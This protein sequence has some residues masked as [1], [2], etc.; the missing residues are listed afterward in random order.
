MCIAHS[1]GLEIEA[2]L[3][4]LGR[5]KATVMPCDDAWAVFLNNL[6]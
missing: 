3:F 1:L 4:A 5:S 6:E 2:L